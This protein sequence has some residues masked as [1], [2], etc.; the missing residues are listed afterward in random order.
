MYTLSSHD[1]SVS[2]V[3]IA[4][5][6]KKLATVCHDQTVRVWNIKTGSLL[7][8]F[9]HNAAIR[10]VAFSGDGKLIASGGADN[11]IKL[12]D[13]RTGKLLRSLGNL[14]TGH[15]DTVTALAFSPNH[16]FVASASLDKTVR[17]WHVKSG[18]EVYALKDYPGAILTLAMG[19]D[20]KT[21]VYGGNGGMLSL[22]HLKTGKPMRT[23]PTNGQPNYSVALS[24]QGFLLAVASGLEIVVWNRQSQKQLFTLQGHTDVV[25]ALAFSADHRTLVS[26]SHDQTIRLWDMKTGKPI[27]TL[28]GHQAAVYSVA[29]SWTGNMIVS[30]GA[31]NVAKIWQRA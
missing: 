28:R 20:G 19:G 17:L 13:I 24:R 16:L 25:S 29:C 7:K 1:G 14:I 11:T 3:A 8:T 4:R 18:K 15:S 21:M 2:G 30:G 6:G 23:F 5:V 9:E 31:D 27:K 12:W 10:C 22:R 26:G